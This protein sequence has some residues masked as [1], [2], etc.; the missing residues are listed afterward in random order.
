MVGSV[1]HNIDIRYNFRYN[2]MYRH[3]SGCALFRIKNKPDHIGKQTP[4]N[5][6]EQFSQSDHDEQKSIKFIPGE[7]I[8]TLVIYDDNIPKAENTINNSSQ[9]KEEHNDVMT[10]LKMMAVS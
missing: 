6:I 5:T 2:T 4:Q 7:V 9:N 1:P 8:P 10:V 3:D